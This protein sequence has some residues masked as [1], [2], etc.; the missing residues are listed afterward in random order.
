M[1]SVKKNMQFQCSQVPKPKG[2]LMKIEYSIAESFRQQT[3]RIAA[4]SHNVILKSNK[5]KL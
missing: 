1:H 2:N 4:I 3:L 5:H